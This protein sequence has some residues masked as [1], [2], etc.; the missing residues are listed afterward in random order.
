MTE[1]GWAGW[2]EAHELPA[3][4]N[5]RTVAEVLSAPPTAAERAQLRAEAAEAEAKRAVVQDV[6]D[7]AAAAQFIAQVNGTPARDPLA[8]GAAE[9]FRDREALG[10]RKRAIELLKPHGLAHVVTGYRSG[11][12][13]DPNMGVLEVPQDERARA[14][15]DRRYES[16]RAEREIAARNRTV[17]RYRE[18]MG[19]R[20]R[21][22]GWRP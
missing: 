2:L 1:A 14:E 9:P 17:D 7:S 4:E 12:V 22:R 13:I 19:E 3:S 5:L 18:R 20:R 11:V 15:L 6:A 16:Q 10:D 21:A 8:A